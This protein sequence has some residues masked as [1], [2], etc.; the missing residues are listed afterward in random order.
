MVHGRGA[1]RRSG[2]TSRDRVGVVRIGRGAALVAA[3]AALGPA[4]GVAHATPIAPWAELHGDPPAYG[5]M[6]GQSVYIDKDGD[7]VVVGAIASSQIAGG[8]GVGEAFVYERAGNVWSQTARLT[9]SE[10]QPDYWFGAAVAVDGGTIAVGASGPVLPNPPTT[11]AGA[12]YLYEKVAGQWAQTAKIVPSD[13]T[14]SN[15]FGYALALHGDT[16]VIGAFWVHKAYVFQRI[17]GIWTQTQVLAG[18]ATGE[19]HFGETIDIDASGTRMVIGAHLADGTVLNQGSVLIYEKSGDT[20]V[21]TARF[22]AN[23]PEVESRFGQFVAIEGDTVLVGARL[24]DDFGVDSG[25]AYVFDRQ[26]DGSWTQT[27][28]LNPSD[29][30]AGDV[31][32]IYGGL[33]GGKLLV[34]APGHAAGGG[35]AGAVYQFVRSGTTWVQTKR[36]DGSTLDSLGFC[37]A[38]SHGFMAVTAPRS[39]KYATRGGRAFLVAVNDVDTDTVPDEYDNCPSNANTDQSDVDHDGVG[40]V[41]EPV[42][43]PSAIQRGGA[44]SSGADLA[45]AGLAI[46]ALAA[47]RSLSRAR[48]RSRPSA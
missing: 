38:V 12:V 48:R 33:A 22:V 8:N 24:K 9:P 30:A 7:T 15:Y 37:L 2:R 21:K 1:S 23:D 25:A 42:G 26:P 45:P 31:F 46:A 6:E 47:A 29:P 10:S 13:P 17:S 40:D 18:G 14:P 11:Y 5:D 4:V 19:W 27:Q 34:G 20:W 16:L 36:I 41:C 39:D 43:C 3:L 28:K 32:G 35:L 44:G